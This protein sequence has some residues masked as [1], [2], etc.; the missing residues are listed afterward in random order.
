MCLPLYSKYVLVG[1]RLHEWALAGDV[2][3]ASGQA[4]F[5]CT[6]D[7]QSAVQ[8][9]H[10]R[11]GQAMPIRIDGQFKAIADFEFGKDRGEV[12]AHGNHADAEPVGNLLIAQ[13]L[14]D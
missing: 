4:S 10:R 14:T 12:M 5:T 2:Q 11:F 13:T 8:K 6:A 9:L 7:C 3:C 1:R